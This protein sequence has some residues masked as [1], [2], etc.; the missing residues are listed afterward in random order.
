MF[1]KNIA[2]GLAAATAEGQNVKALSTE[3]AFETAAVF[4]QIL[5][6]ETGST[7]STAMRQFVAKMDTFVPELKKELRDGTVTKLTKEQIN[8][9]SRAGTIG[10]RTELMRSNEP[11][12][13]QFLEGIE[14][15]E[16]KV[17]I[18]ELVQ[19][20]MR[21]LEVE[22]KAQRAVTGIDAAQ[23]QFQ[24]LVGALGSETAALSSDRVVEAER[25]RQ[26]VI[27]GKEGQ[28]VKLYEDFLTKENL[29]GID[30]FEAQASR[31]Q[32]AARTEIGGESVSSAAIDLIRAQTGRRGTFGQ[33][34]AERTREMGERAIE[35]IEKLNELIEL[36]R[37]SNRIA[38][39]Q[40]G[41]GRRMQAMEVRP[42][43]APLPAATVP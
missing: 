18:R 38:Q 7:T 9:F 40:Q 16:A 24:N 39:Q 43:E 37:E 33:L 31:A 42:K 10:E 30:S 21:A 25:Q 32:F 6:D 17:P 20:T 36:Q 5:K 29:L 13:R 22:Q 8:Q 4:S 41:A 3:Q 19:G 28:I 35:Q 15:G 34:P 1:S 2:P 14:E 11:L 27:Q 26:Q 23:P 12:R